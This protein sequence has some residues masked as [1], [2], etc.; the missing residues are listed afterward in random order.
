MKQDI[1][2]PN[3]NQ[4]YQQERLGSHQKQ[5]PTKMQEHNMDS[6]SSPQPQIRIRKEPFKQKASYDLAKFEESL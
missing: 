6:G 3:S 4:D 2:K 1:L 5:S